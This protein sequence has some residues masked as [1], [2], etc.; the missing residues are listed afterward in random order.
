MPPPDT[1]T[2]RVIKMFWHTFPNRSEAS[3]ILA[4]MTLIAHR[5]GTAAAIDL[6]KRLSV[7]VEANSAS[8]VMSFEREG[9]A[10]CVIAP[11][12][13]ERTEVALLEHL[14]DHLVGELRDRKNVS[15]SLSR[16]VKS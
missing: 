1:H 5:L 14:M 8:T 12:P 9:F 13:E 4:A 10:A 6:A 2:D 11:A 16:P 15:A 3:R 7:V